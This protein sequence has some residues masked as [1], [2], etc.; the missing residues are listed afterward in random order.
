[1]VCSVSL[2]LVWVNAQS[3]C[4]LNTLCITA[5]FACFSS[6]DLFNDIFYV[7]TVYCRMIDEWWF[8]NDLKGSGRGPPSTVPSF[9]WKDCWKS[10]NSATITSVS[11]ETRTD[12]LPNTS[13]ELIFIFVSAI[14]TRARWRSWLRHYA[15]SWKVA[16]SSPCWGGFF[17][18]Q[19]T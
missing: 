12:Y 10:G 17:F 15:T 11:V 2:W 16:G 6:V 9:V 8:K 3:A 4:A 7:E 5:N 18:L 14:Y 19:F 1:M 13:L